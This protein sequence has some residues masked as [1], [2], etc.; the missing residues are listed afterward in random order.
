VPEFKVYALH[1]AVMRVL[2]ASPSFSTS[3][4]VLGGKAAPTLV[5]CDLGM[6]LSVNK[7]VQIQGLPFSHMRGR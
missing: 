5:P 2:Q 1:S 6:S 4:L 7:A 3:Y